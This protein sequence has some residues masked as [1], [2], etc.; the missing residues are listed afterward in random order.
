[1]ATLLQDADQIAADEAAGTSNNYEIIFGHW[2]PST[3][4]DGFTGFS[5]TCE[6]GAPT[7]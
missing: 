5:M 2:W 4:R 6:L 1:M 3:R 7:L